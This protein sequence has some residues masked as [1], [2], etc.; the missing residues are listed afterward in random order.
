MLLKTKQ[1]QLINSNL[2]IFYELG[3]VKTER[4]CQPSLSLY[5]AL[6]AAALCTLQCGRRHTL[7]ILYLHIYMK[8]KKHKH[9]EAKGRE[10][11]QTHIYQR[12]QETENN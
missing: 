1:K 5:C 12:D 9:R 8:E 3:G 6:R 11:R 10:K 4:H 2:L 7:F